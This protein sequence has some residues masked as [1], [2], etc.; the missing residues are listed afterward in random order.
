MMCLLN[1]VVNK[2]LIVIYPFLSGYLTGNA[3][4]LKYLIFIIF[5]QVFPLQLENGERASQRIRGCNLASDDSDSN[6]DFGK[7]DDGFASDEE[8]QDDE[9]TPCTSTTKMKS[10]TGMLLE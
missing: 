2:I 7:D 6:R 3:A 5:K 10:L 1:L 9:F 4:K 8:N